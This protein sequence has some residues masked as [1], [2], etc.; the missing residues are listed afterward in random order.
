MVFDQGLGDLMVVRVAG[1]VVN[2]FVMGSIVNAVQLLGVRLVMVMGHTKCGMVARAV[3]NWAK[4]EA[5]KLK[6]GDAQGA[7]E[8][9]TT[10]RPA[11][12]PPTGGATP[13]AAERENG[14]GKHHRGGGSFS[15]LCGCGGAP[16]TAGDADAPMAASAA[17]EARPS[18][19]S[20]QSLASPSQSGGGRRTSLGRL[21]ID[22]LSLSPIGAIVG[23]I[24]AAVD[25]VANNNHSLS[26][27]VSKIHRN[28]ELSELGGTGLQTQDSLGITRARLAKQR[29]NENL[30]LLNQIKDMQ[31]VE[32][33]ATQNT[34]LSAKAVLKG[35]VRST[36]VA[37]CQ[38]LEVVAAKYDLK[39]GK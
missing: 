33:V 17:D 10:P 3:H 9:A 34:V 8:A 38:E 28:E 7:A 19:A 24:G 20:G 11:G 29:L 13:F 1:N 27:I 4:H 31:G 18:S 21:T 26:H 39:D 32:E 30:T 22:R 6:G 25:H 14:G 23:S 5:R 16:A 36:D 2:D 12:L 37:I 35:L 15:R